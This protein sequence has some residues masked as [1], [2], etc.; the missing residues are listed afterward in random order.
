MKREKEQVRPKGSIENQI[1]DWGVYFLLFIVVVIC[2]YPF[3]N[4]FI[5]S[6]ND[7]S[8]TVRGGLYLWPRKFTLESYRMVFKNT[9]IWHAAFISLSRSIVGTIVALFFTTLL[10][11]AMSKKDLFGGKVISLFFVFTM[12]FGGGLIP[13]YM[14]LKAVHLIDT[15]WVYI[16]PS[17]IGVYN[18]ILI[19]IYMESL[20]V[21]LE[22]SAYLDGAGEARTFFSIILPLIKPVLATVGLFVAVGQWG[23]WFD[24]NLYTYKTSLS[25]LQFLLVQILNNYNLG[26][27]KS[28][29]QILAEVAKANT[30]S[31][32][33]IRMATAM[34]A[35][36][37]ILIVYPFVQKYFVK[38][39]M[40]GA[41][42]G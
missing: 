12:Y 9:A 40:I 17:A 37:P 28:S 31:S 3:W 14:V 22:E 39:M 23:S 13:Y 7:A 27:S 32:N 42:K 20:P 29:T 18:M 38:G 16:I 10:A 4:I 2:L 11:Y 19:R 5:L 6:I 8:D 41:V 25:T 34:V 36:V 21:E 26:T 30:I 15:F 33:S 35:T 1:F 24:T